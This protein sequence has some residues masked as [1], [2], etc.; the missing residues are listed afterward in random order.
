M[1]QNIL[2]YNFKN[3]SRITH[4]RAWMFPL[5]T[6][7]F[8]ERWIKQIYRFAK[9]CNAV[10]SEV[11]EYRNP[12]AW[13][14]LVSLSAS[15]PVV[16]STTEQLLLHYVPVRVLLLLLLLQVSLNQWL[17]FQE[18]GLLKVFRA[19]KTKLVGT[20][21]SLFTDTMFFLSPNQQHQSR[22]IRHYHKLTP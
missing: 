3:M 14:V 13:F 12:L 16:T 11:R 10:T 5:L 19:P 6:W 17:M 8:S 18:L 22:L 20:V 15:S 4:F 1:M 9:C 2:L 7:D 21:P